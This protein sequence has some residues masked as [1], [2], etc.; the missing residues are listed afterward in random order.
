MIRLPC[1]LDSER[2]ELTL[3]CHQT[4][5]SPAWEPE[6][7]IKEPNTYC[8]FGW[9]CQVWRDELAICSPSSDLASRKPLLSALLKGV[10]RGRGLPS[11][12]GLAGPPLA[13]P[14]AQ[15]HRVPW[16]SDSDT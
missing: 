11:P 2:G 6:E 13:R 9:R 15:G 10:G 5:Q 8:F 7:K 3:S 16:A 14:T 1:G 4:F 12:C